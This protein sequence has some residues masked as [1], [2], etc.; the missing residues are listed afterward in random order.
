[1]P[2]MSGIALAEHIIERHPGVGVV[3]LSGY[4]AETLDLKRMMEHGAVFLAKPVTR[5][6]LLAALR[7]VSPKPRQ[8]SDRR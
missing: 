1:M 6:D 7:R 5:N 8:V 4:T 2:G 3:M